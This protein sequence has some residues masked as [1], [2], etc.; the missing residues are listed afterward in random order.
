M[1]E[2]YFLPYFEEK[3]IHTIDQLEFDAIDMETGFC[4]IIRSYNDDDGLKAPKWEHIRK[5]VP[6]SDKALEAIRYVI[7]HYPYPNIQPDDLE[8][9]L[10]RLHIDRDR[11]AADLPKVSDGKSAPL[12]AEGS[13]LPVSNT[14]TETKAEEELS[15]KPYLS[16][17][18]LSRYTG[19]PKGTLYK[20]THR[21]EI[22]FSRPGGALIFDRKKIDRWLEKHEWKAL[23]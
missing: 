22:P 10:T 16:M 6:L 18:E 1:V 2:D 9:L 20:M 4:H 3:N 7:D 8:E 12:I 15:S 13:K 11:L 14:D 21:R 17:E 23:F 19:I 5:D